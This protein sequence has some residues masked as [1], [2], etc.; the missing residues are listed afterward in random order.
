[1]KTIDDSE[2]APERQ[3]DLIKRPMRQRMDVMVPPNPKEPM[4]RMPMVDQSFPDDAE[5]EAMQREHNLMNLQKRRRAM[6]KM[7]RFRARGTRT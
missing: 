3:P 5:A 7:R 1:M 6:Q 2:D 4:T